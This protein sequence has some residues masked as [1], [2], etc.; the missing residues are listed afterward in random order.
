MLAS[1]GCYVADCEDRHTVLRLP[2]VSSKDTLHELE[3]EVSWRDETGPHQQKVVPSLQEVGERAQALRLPLARGCGPTTYEI[4]LSGF[5]GSQRQ[6]DAVR[7][8][9]ASSTPSCEKQ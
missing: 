1:G 5:H 7:A 6:A 9:C 3:A 8:E 2:C 4:R